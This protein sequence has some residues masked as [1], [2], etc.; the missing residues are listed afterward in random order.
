MNPEPMNIVILGFSLTSRLGNGHVT[1]YRGL[2]RSLCARGHQ[3]LYLERDNPG[4]AASQDLSNTPSGKAERYASLEDLRERFTDEVAGADAV[5]VGSFVPEGIA[6]GAWV[7]K[8]AKGV[9]AFYDSD[10]SATLSHL[11]GRDCEYLDPYMICEFSLYLSVT[12]GPTLDYLETKMGSP[13]A[14]PLYCGFDPDIYY[15]DPAAWR[16]DLGYWG[17]YAEDRKSR[18]ETLLVEPARRRSSFSMVVAG[19]QYPADLPWPKNVERIDS[20]PPEAQ[21]R[22]YN[23]LRFAVNVSREPRK[24]TGYSPGIRLFEAAACG[25]PIISD[26]WEGLDEFFSIGE[27]IIVARDAEEVLEYLDG[28][29]E[30]QRRE[31]GERARARAV[32]D[33]TVAG[34]AETLEGYLA[35]E[36]GPH[37]KQSPVFDSERKIT[38]P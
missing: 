20:L 34:R 37:R 33:H 38:T 15:P 6:V 13:R 28:M 4:Y 12:G 36:M 19:S 10:T 2:I 25:V 16:W 22:F 29:G 26:G 5:I 18:L 3:I 30:T 24:Q 1:Y 31:I 14:R 17:N 11:A 21:N 32:R 35:E 23:S 7:L 27:E 8:T 9:T